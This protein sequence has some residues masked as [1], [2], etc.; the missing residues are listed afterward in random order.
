MSCEKFPSTFLSVTQR[1][2]PHLTDAA[3]V[4]RVHIKACK[5]LGGAESRA[6]LSLP[7]QTGLPTLSSGQHDL[8]ISTNQSDQQKQTITIFLERYNKCLNQLFKVNFSCRVIL[9]RP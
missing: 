6:T 9:P 3:L 4:R 8:C 1:E 5:Y 2:M 7:D